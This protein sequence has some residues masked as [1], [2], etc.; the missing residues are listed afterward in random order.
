MTV[1]SL[2]FLIQRLLSSSKKNFSEKSVYVQKWSCCEWRKRKNRGPEWPW[3]LFLAGFCKSVFLFVLPLDFC[4]LKESLRIFSFF[5][6]TFNVL[7]SD[8]SKLLI[9]YNHNF[10]PTV[11]LNKIKLISAWLLGILICVLCAFLSAAF[12]LHMAG[13]LHLKSIQMYLEPKLLDL[14][15]QF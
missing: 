6:V 13:T 1:N 14:V 9:M 11:L 7:I 2:H 3:G 5:S 8:F 10:F 4:P 15:R 12:V